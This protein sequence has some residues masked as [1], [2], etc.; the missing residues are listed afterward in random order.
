[1][2][3]TLLEI[4]EKRC[5]HSAIAL[6]NAP[7]LPASTLRK[8]LL[9]N[10]NTSVSYVGASNQDRHQRELHTDRV[11]HTHQLAPVAIESVGGTDRACH[12]LPVR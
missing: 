10:R 6:P 2:A 12:W 4:C 8:M 9:A 11:A 3:L 1:M 7:T 5:V